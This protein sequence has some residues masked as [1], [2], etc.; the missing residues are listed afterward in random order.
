M[1]SIFFIFLCFISIG[2]LSAQT[3]INF[4]FKIWKN[5]I[6]T[7]NYLGTF[8]GT[9]NNANQIVT[10]NA[11]AQQ[12]CPGDELIIKQFC[13]KNGSQHNFN[14]AST[15]SRGQISVSG[16]NTHGAGVTL[17]ADIC[18]SGGGSGCS[19]SP[20]HF[21][22]WNWGYNHSIT[23][24]VPE[25]NYA[26]SY[27]AFSSSIIGSH[28][29]AH[30]CGIRTAFIPLNIAPST[31]VAD[32]T[33]CPGDAVTIPSV[34]GFT[35]TNWSP[36]NPNITAPTTTTN[37]T[38][39]ITH[40][41]GCT[42]TDNFTISVSNPNIDLSLIRSL[43]YDESTVFTEDD[44]SNLHN[45]T[46]TPLSLTANGVT[47]FDFLNGNVYDVP[48]V[49][50]APTYGTGI[51]TFDYTYSENGITCTKSYE[52][53]IHPQIVLNL[54]SAYGFCSGNFQP[55]FATNNGI[56]GQPGITYIWTQSGVPFSV[57]TGPYFTPSSFG[58][59]FVTASDESG[60]QVRRSF[61]VYDRG[62]GIKHPANITFCSINQA[63]PSYIGW[64][65]D[66]FGPTQYSFSWTY[67]D[68]SGTTVSIT[69]TGPQYQVPYQGSGTYTTVVNA[70]GCTET[71]SI[72][73]T[74]LF[75]VY[76]NSSAAAFSFI[77]LG[78]NQVSCQPTTSMPGTIP[79]WI[80]VNQSTNT[81]VPATTSGGGIKF[82]Y[83]NGVQYLV[84]F[85]RLDVRNCKEYKNQFTWIDNFGKVRGKKVTDNNTK[86]E[87]SNASVSTFP[88]PTTGLVNIQLKDLETATTQIQV[89]NALGQVVLNQEVQD[90]TNIEIDLSKE[91][92]GVYILQIVNGD[93][94][95]SE[96]II[97]E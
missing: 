41:T 49:I 22:Y 76:N 27:L 92:S 54:Q 90:Q 16:S 8:N 32:Q 85:R 35:Y 43:C 95:L 88:N 48:H 25:T 81:Q 56:V 24:T 14:G 4:S 5:S 65:S 26:T 66:P 86:L 68:V 79:L 73:V 71:I 83:V 55:I 62:V 11:I 29:H 46:T 20:V 6:T 57:G 10:T 96:K 7:A 58:T 31:S 40:A 78:G 53:I 69:N 28:I 67:T 15:S 97:K 87:V 60:C 12:I 74:D 19:T 61:T 36:S 39:D 23:I 84:T 51:I 30:N 42:K 44:L 9:T 3:N 94:Q 77:P 34:S 18:P 93:T 21:P 45:G 91:T 17:I 37:Y 13:Y 63:E 59:Y 52:M 47:I 75:Q 82:N 50:D 64:S 1:K 70:N 80:V 2:S 33:I 72:V 89:F 38:V